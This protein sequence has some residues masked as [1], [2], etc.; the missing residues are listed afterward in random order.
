MGFFGDS[1]S[2]SREL[3]MGIFHFGLDQKIPANLKARG[4]GSEIWDQFFGMKFFKIWGFLFPGNGYSF[5]SG[6]VY[7]GDCGF[8][9][10]RYFWRWG[11]FSLDGISHR[12]A[13]SGLGSSIIYVSKEI[14]FISQTFSSIIGSGLPGS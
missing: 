6:D 12:K 1:R 3:G 7:R 8:F 2:A 5:K 9:Y 10:L 11:F 14:M 4:W 13:T